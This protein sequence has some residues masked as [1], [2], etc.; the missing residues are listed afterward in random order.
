MSEV[1]V[2][3]VDGGEIHHI[4]SIDVPGKQK[5]IRA[6]RDW[7][8]GH[9][10]DGTTYRLAKFV[11]PPVRAEETTVMEALELPLSEPKPKAK[12]TVKLKSDKPAAVEA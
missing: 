3:S 6:L 8:K 5:R 10:A 12:D 11:T 1:V 9:G 2:L 4:A 7:I